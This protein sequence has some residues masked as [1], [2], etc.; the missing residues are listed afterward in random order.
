MRFILAGFGSQSYMKE[1]RNTQRVSFS[2][3]YRL[4]QSVHSAYGRNTTSDIV[5][6]YWIE[7][8]IHR[9]QL[10]GLSRP[11]LDLSVSQ[12]VRRSADPVSQSISQSTGRS[13]SRPVSQ[14]VSDLHSS[15]PSTSMKR[16]SLGESSEQRGEI[17]WVIMKPSTSPISL[18]KHDIEFIDSNS[19]FALLQHLVIPF[20]GR[21][22]PT[23][24]LFTIMIRN[25]RG[26]C[27]RQIF[28]RTR[29]LVPDPAWDPLA[30]W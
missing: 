8:W 15:S 21:P 26:C 13:V 18:Q 5:S 29:D 1:L 16:I 24:C 2:V 10:D 4:C 11:K 27:E 23:A 12:S 25:G 20:R 17:I 7:I 14:S 22:K 6:S 30:Y 19:F 9:E 28:A 3:H